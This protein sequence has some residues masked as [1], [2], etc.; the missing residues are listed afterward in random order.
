ME[1]LTFNSGSQWSLHK[2]AK[3]PY[4]SPEGGQSTPRI[5]GQPDN[6]FRAYRSTT[7]QLREDH[8]QK[9][10]T[11]GNPGNKRAPKQGMP[12]KHQGKPAT[13]L[14]SSAANTNPGIGV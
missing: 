4:S 12:L 3:S 10:L 1:Y 6:D 7:G 2:S 5:A 8:G 14:P 11:H 9:G 13:L